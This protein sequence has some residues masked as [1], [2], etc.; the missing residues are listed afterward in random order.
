MPGSGVCRKRHRNRQVPQSR[1]CPQPGL[2]RRRADRRHPAGLAAAPGSR[3]SP[4]QSRAQD[5]ALPNPALCR[6]PDR[7]RLKIAATRPWASAIVHAWE[8]VT[9]QQVHRSPLAS[10]PRAAR[11]RRPGRG[12]EGTV[13]GGFF[14]DRL[15]QAVPQV[16]SVTDLRRARQRAA[17]HK[18]QSHHGTRPERRDEHPATPRGRQRCG[19]AARRHAAPSPRR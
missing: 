12:P 6:P 18:P 2:A 17:D 15:G 9:T 7:Q 4:R 19:R 16:P 1:L 11:R 3:W 14:A 13:R 8:R 5:A 10:W